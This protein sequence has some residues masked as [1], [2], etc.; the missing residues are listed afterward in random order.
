MYH[1]AEI[2]PGKAFGAS[3]VTIVGSLISALVVLERE[4]ISLL[5][6]LSSMCLHPF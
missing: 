6:L 2:D 4:L 5:E 1:R 3:V